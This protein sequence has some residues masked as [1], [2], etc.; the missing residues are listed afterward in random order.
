KRAV[1]HLVPYLEAEKA[2][3]GDSRAR[4]KILMATVKGDVHDIGKNI[5]GV[6]LACNNYEVVDLGVMV[7]VARILDEAR[8][9]NVDVIGLSGLITPS[10][11]EMAHV[12]GELEREE[13][14]LPLLIGGATTSRAHTAVKIAP[15]Y[16]GPVVHVAD[17]SR[18]VGVVS[19]LL[20]GGAVA[21][22]AGVREDQ[23]RTRVERAGRRERIV[24]VSIEVARANRTPV[25]FGRPGPRPTLLG[26]RDFDVALSDLIDWIDWT[27]FFGAWELK[28]AFPGILDDRRVGESARPL[29]EDGRRLLDRIVAERL[30]R[31]KAVVGFWPASSVGDD[32][33]LYADEGR[34]E[35]LA[36]VHT[37]RQQMEKPPGRPNEALADFVAPRSGNVPDYLG[38]FA[39]TA[40]IG[41]AELVASF[42][43]ANDDYHAIMSKALADRLAEATAEYVHAKVRRELW[44]YAP[45]EAPDNA[46][47]IREEYQGIR[48]APGYPA[49]PDHTEKATLFALLDAE[50]RAGISLTESFAMLPP[51]SVSGYYFWRPEAHY[52]GIGR[53]GRDQLE[54]YARR[55]GW[56]I[57]EAARWL[58]PN[59]DDE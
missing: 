5:V 31:A 49:C 44:G 28:G 51:A 56:S 33:E 13:F 2:A 47:M 12:A 20:G 39:V 45:S 30:L 36:A 42:E 15:R 23:E 8:G 11:E 50:A 6:V 35:T 38:G 16:S 1:A 34:G 32:I 26:A 25:D 55:K 21:Y 14:R 27:P 4:G 29:Y 57:E 48:P 40:G 54:D 24:K 52:F 53:I 18:A 9:Q 46:Q 37:L 19:E 22:A 58:A 59:L 7:P 17:A 43:A 3:L 10:L 41:S